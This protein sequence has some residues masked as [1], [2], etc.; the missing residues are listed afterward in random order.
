M[1][2]RTAA[3]HKIRFELG[4]TRP[5]RWVPEGFPA[6]ICWEGTWAARVTVP[7]GTD[8][9][10][11][12]PLGST[13]P[14]QGPALP[15]AGAAER[16]KRAE[17]ARGALCPHRQGTA[18]WP[19]APR[20]PVSSPGG[21]RGRCA[22]RSA[23]APRGSRSADRAA[24]AKAGPS[25]TPTCQH[26]ETPRPRPTLRGAARP[27]PAAQIAPSRGPRAAV[28]NAGGGGGE[29]AGAEASPGAPSNPHPRTPPQHLCG[30][31]AG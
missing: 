20:W 29:G 9:P 26:R 12:V 3:T 27:R 6:V 17:K 7:T 18:W 31:D 15:L 8:F 5:R 21:R 23:A 16:Q 4:K 1:R 13:E 22:E 25:V 30:S 10:C 19:A 2:S 24:G 28:Q 14:A 11:E